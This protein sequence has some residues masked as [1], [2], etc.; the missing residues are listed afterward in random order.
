MTTKYRRTLQRDHFSR[1]HGHD[2]LGSHRRSSGA[3]KICDELSGEEDTKSP[4][5]IDLPAIIG[6]SRVQRLQHQ[7]RLLN[8]LK[9][10]ITARRKPFR[11][12]AIRLSWIEPH[13]R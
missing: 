7:P 8:V 12:K 5:N 6:F 10:A 4:R 11:I 9:T 3:V 1:I 2:G 13:H